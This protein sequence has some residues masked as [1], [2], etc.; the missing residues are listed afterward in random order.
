MDDSNDMTTATSVYDPASNQWSSGPALPGQPIDGFGQAAM[1]TA[2]GLF[3]TTCAGLL[4]RLSQD[5]KAWEE[6]G[7]LNHPRSF[8][9]LVADGDQRLLI[10]GGTARGGKVA[11]VESIE[12]VPAIS[13]P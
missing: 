8:H 6:V 5:G 10:V 12:L 2:A 13:K 4:V 9:R 7:K 1:G 11:A 3:A